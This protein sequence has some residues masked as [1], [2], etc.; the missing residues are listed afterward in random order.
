[1]LV[2]F[3]AGMGLFMFVGKEELFWLMNH[4]HSILGD[5]FFKYITYLG[6]GL[7][8]ILLGL[9]FLAFGK[10]KLGI[11]L[12][13]SFLLSGLI[14]QIFKRVMPEPRPGKYFTE[15]KRSDRVHHVDGHLLK[16][17]N[18]FPSGHTTTAFAL[19]SMLAFDNRWYRWQVLFF[20]CAVIV[21]YSRV[22]LGQHFFKDI[23]AGALL[24][25]A[26][27]LFLLWIFRKKEF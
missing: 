5:Y 4:Q 2:L 27:S 13:L 21:G 26:T 12:I 25:Y 15:I 19:F 22:Y 10:R 3:F 9:I 23:W 20:V 1:M 17:D 14:V 24:G 11:L 6:D 16:G 8:M 18:S 7:V